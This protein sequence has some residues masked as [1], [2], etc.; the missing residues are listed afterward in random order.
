M[1]RYHIKRIIVF[2]IICGYSCSEEQTGEPPLLSVP[3]VNLANVDSII[4]FGE[5]L[6]DQSKNPAFEYI[7]NNSSEVVYACS[8]GKVGEILQN[9]GFSDVEIHIKPTS[10]SEW[11]LIYD[12]VKEVM[13]S[14]GQFVEAGTILGLVG[15]GNR[16]E[17]Q[18][19]QFE[20]AMTVA[21]C[22]F[23]Y[24]MESFMEEHLIY[25]E[26]WCLADTIKP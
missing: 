8:S 26:N 10:V 23:H 17:L 4:A 22:P 6:T 16:T 1:Y 12:H 9:E 24:A 3:P 13:V 19:N 2:L 18:L 5:D 21:H 11:T 7:L 25:S 14:K 15:E 20:S